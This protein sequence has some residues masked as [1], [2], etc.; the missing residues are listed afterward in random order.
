MR[1]ARPP[2][3]ARADAQD[4]TTID[5]LDDAVKM[6]FPHG[7]S[8]AY[9]ESLLA[10]YGFPR[11]AQW[12]SR[13]TLTNLSAVI[14]RDFDTLDAWQDARDQDS[15]ID[16]IYSS[17]TAGRYHMPPWIIADILDPLTGQPKPRD[18]TQTYWAA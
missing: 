1:D 13:L 5:H 15:A 3:R 12:R 4:M 2:L 10:D 18:G 11:S 7:I 17:V 9:P 6:M 8:N 16:I 14:D